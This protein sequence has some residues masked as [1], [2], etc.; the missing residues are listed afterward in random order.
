VVGSSTVSTDAEVI[1]LDAPATVS[2]FLQRMGRSGRR[3][4]SRRNCLFLVTTPQALLLTVGVVEKWSQAWVEESRPPPEPWNV[5]AQQ[6]LA[7]T[8]EQGQ[9]PRVE[10]MEMLGRALPEL[11]PLDFAIL[12]MEL[13]AKAYLFEPAQGLLQAGPT[14]E[15]DFGR[16]H[17]RDLLVVFTGAVLLS[18]KHGNADVGYIDPSVLTGDDE[19]KR[20]MLAGMSW[21][22]RSVDWR[23]RTAW[24]EPVGSGGEARWTGGL[25]SIGSEV[26]GAIRLVLE[27]GE[28]AAGVL[29]RRA[30]AELNELRETIP[31]GSPGATVIAQANGRCRMWAFAGMVANRTLARRMKSAGSSSSDELEVDFRQDPRGLASDLPTKELDLSQ[32][33]LTKTAS[34]TKFA[35]MLPAGLLHRLVLTRAIGVAPTARVV[36]RDMPADV[37]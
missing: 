9:A 37:G 22:V 17:Y 3:A 1:Q 8:L 28:I 33:E 24:L 18:A 4:G 10:L 29:S 34:T 19:E 16:S 21:V 23:R 5:V 30:R 2:S 25:R 36:E 14:C 31:L 12:L 35:A 26:A 11:L 6:A 7:M 27:R 15:A 13:I 20:I 32:S